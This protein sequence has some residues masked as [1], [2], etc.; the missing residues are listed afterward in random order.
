MALHSHREANVNETQLN[1]P[2]RT[3]TAHN[4]TLAYKHGWQFLRRLLGGRSVSLWEGLESKRA[5]LLFLVLAAHT[6][7]LSPANKSSRPVGFR[8]HESILG[9]FSLDLIRTCNQVCS[10]LVQPVT[11]QM[12]AHVMLLAHACVWCSSKS[13]EVRA[14]GIFDCE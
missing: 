5:P 14:V 1:R 2:H 10:L 4:P 13:V 6:H 9:M 11:S 7:P 12:R 8:E 3:H